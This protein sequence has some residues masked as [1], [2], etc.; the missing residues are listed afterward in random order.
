LMGNPIMYKE[1]K[2][3]VNRYCYSCVLKARYCFTVRNIGKSCNVYT[4]N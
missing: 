2:I 4:D 1:I 3:N